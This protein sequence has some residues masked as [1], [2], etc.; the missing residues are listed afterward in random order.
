MDIDWRA[1]VWLFHAFFLGFF[2]SSCFFYQIIHFFFCLG[3]DHST[4][5]PKQKTSKRNKIP[6]SKKKSERHNIKKKQQEPAV[7]EGHRADP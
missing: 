6:K 4:A 1:R 7:I 5:Q 2:F 3:S